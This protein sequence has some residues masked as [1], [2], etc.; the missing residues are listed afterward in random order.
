MRPSTK[1]CIAGLKADVTEI[2]KQLLRI[3]DVIDDHGR[4]VLTE[5][6]LSSLNSWIDLSKGAIENAKTLVA[7]A[8]EK[9]APKQP[10]KSAWEIEFETY[11]ER[12]TWNYEPS[13]SKRFA[14]KQ[15]EEYA[16][17][18]LDPVREAKL[19][20]IGFS[21]ESPVKGY[22]FRGTI[23]APRPGE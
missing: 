1:S 6:E 12:M 3:H 16:A 19:R 18:T 7:K 4:N 13:S 2:E 11:Q 20:S 15:R 8:K 23:R 17:G 14:A 21:F 5:D 10:R 22:A 9:Y